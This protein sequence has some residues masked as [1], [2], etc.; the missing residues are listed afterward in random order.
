MKQIVNIPKP[1]ESKR[2]KQAIHPITIDTLLNK[3]KQIRKM[4]NDP[5]ACTYEESNESGDEEAKI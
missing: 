3:K 1:K 4:T 5:I 2:Q